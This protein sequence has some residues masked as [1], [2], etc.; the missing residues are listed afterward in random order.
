MACMFL[1]QDQVQDTPLF[2][3]IEK[4][5]EG[6][7]EIMLQVPSLNLFELNRR[8]FNMLQLASLKGHAR[9]ASLPSLPGRGER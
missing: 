2:D 3:A 7:V 6:I 8:G 9:Y 4:D 1:S 5:N